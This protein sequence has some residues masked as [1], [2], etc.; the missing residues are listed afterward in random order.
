[1]RKLYWNHLSIATKLILVM[2]SMIV[3]S[4]MGV[5]LLSIR[6]TQRNL[7]EEL[8][9]NA[10]LVLDTLQAEVAHRDSM[11]N[12]TAL[13]AMIEVMAQDERILVSGRIYDLEGRLVIDA[14]QPTAA[15]SSDVDPLGQQLIKSDQT[16]FTW[17][18]DQLLAGRAIVIADERL[19]AMSV[20]LPLARFE[21]KVASVRN[22]GLMVAAVTTTAGVLMAL[23]LG[24]SIT[25]PLRDSVA[26][27]ERIARG[28][29]MQQIAVSDGRDETALLTYAME[30]MRSEMQELYENLENQ[31]TQRTQEL[32]KSDD[33]FRRVISSISDVVYMAE[34]SQDQQWVYRFLSPG[35]EKLVGYPA[36]QFMQ[37]FHSWESLMHL[38]DRSVF[39]SHLEQLVE[40][41]NSEVEYRLFHANGDL[42]W[43]RDSG[44]V[45]VET[46]QLPIV[47]YGVISNITERQE[48][49][50]ERER[51]LFA[52]REQR[53]LAETLTEVTLALTSQTSL[54]TLLDEILRQVRRIVP[55]CVARI[56]LLEGDKLQ[57]VRWRR[58]KPDVGHRLVSGRIQSLTELPNEARILASRQPMVISE[59]EHEPGWV[60]TAGREWVRSYLAV[61]L[62][63]HD[64]VLGLLQL[65]GSSANDF[66]AADARKLQPLA[67][68]A[69]I[70]IENARLVADL[71]GMVT[72]RTADI[73]TEQE[74]SATIL[75]N[76]SDAIIMIGL[77]MR[78]RYV[79]RAFSVLTG[80]MA[81]EVMGKSTEVVGIV[82]D[83]SEAA[84]KVD[85]HVK[86]WQSEAIVQR[87]DGQTY[88]AAVTVA[89]VFGIDGQ[90]IGYVSSHRDISQAKAL[91]RVRGRF[92]TN[93]S[94]QLRTPVTNIK[95]YVELLQRGGS[96]EKHCKYMK[97]LVEQTNRLEHLVQD[98]LEMTSLD[99]RSV[100]ATRQTI[101]TK[102]LVGTIAKRYQDRI[103]AANLKM[104]TYAE[105]AN[106][107]SVKGDEAW[108]TRALSELIDN[109]IAFTPPGGTIQ[110]DTRT[111]QRDSRWWSCIAVGDTG[112]GVTIDEQKR[113]FDRFYRGKLAEAGHIPGTGLGLSIVTEIARAHGGKVTLESGARGGSKFTVWLPAT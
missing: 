63:Q 43:I 107:V 31:V 36:E 69:A 23:L 70:A 97:V 1:V 89:P 11:L 81:E 14:F 60:T 73:Q 13:A 62:C 22:E 58:Y 72:A 38:D 109:A 35:L 29:L 105:S 80:F 64:Q 108:L 10:E 75:R 26:A 12:A 76:V 2:T 15:T 77:D 92:M 42:V 4:V 45:E 51:L 98:I 53:L 5:T 106:G 104:T 85:M 37:N 68:A 100:T 52:E 7:Q 101:S 46:S 86:S 30:R 41:Q 78:I 21:D 99:S 90:Q 47:V 40:G 93:V 28:D 33:R 39:S 103:T 67:N 9:Q 111:V 48:A 25:G 32:R 113:I 66:S 19:G 95:L 87:K 84:K 83:A 102:D 74:R 65:D 16:L 59:T 91:E 57:L 24:R 79:N 96:V 112:P 18:E 44:Q 61:P 71:E 8:E 3:I 49:A 50:V 94:H 82:M 56:S 34:I 20:S 54:E 88:D 6:R 110:I 17:H 27:T 55:Y